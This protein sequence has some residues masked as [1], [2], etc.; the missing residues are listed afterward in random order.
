MPERDTTPMRPGLWMKPGM[1]PIL[2]C[3][4]VMMPGQFGPIRRQSIIAQRR[5]DAHHVEH[6]NALG[7]ADDEL[8]T[9]VRRF[10]NGVRGERRR[11]ENHADVGAGLCHGLA[12][13]VEH[14]HAEVLLAAATGR[15]AGNDL[16]AVV[17]ALLRVKRAL[18]AGEC[19]GR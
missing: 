19:P 17:D 9:G 10:E 12:H 2:H 15:D 5:L 4:G 16:R 14:R 13:G 8:D 18:A 3:S 6:R 11:H 1:M 7:D